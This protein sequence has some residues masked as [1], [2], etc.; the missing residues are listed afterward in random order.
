MEEKILEILKVSRNNGLSKQ[1]VYKKLAYTNLSFEDFEEVFDDL[2]TRQ[3]IYQTGKDKYTL[4]PFKEAEI[5]ITRKGLIL[6]KTDK[7]TYEISEDQFNCLTGDKVKIRI[8]DFNQK[9]G[10][11]KEV[12]TRKGTPAEVKIENGKK[13]AIVR[14]KENETKYELKTDENLVDGILIGIKLEKNRK[15]KQPVATLDRIFGHKNKPRLDEE[16]IL[17]E[18]NFNYEWPEEVKN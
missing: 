11:I 3:E 5:Q 16:I 4:N 8:T 18:N 2:Q 7:D 9:K 6:A 1:E 14:N 17:Y 15:D 12:L 10:T 13:Y